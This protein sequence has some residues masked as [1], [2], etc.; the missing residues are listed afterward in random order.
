MRKTWRIV[1]GAALMTG[2]LCAAGT[3]GTQTTRQVPPPPRPPAPLPPLP[4]TQLDDRLPAFKQTFSLSFSD[5][6]PIRDVLLLMLKDTGLSVVIDPDVTG[7]FTG[8]LAGVTLKQALDITLQPLALEYAIEN[9]VL[10]VFRRPTETRF[11][12]VNHVAT[13]RSGERTTGA[14]TGLATASR[15]ADGVPAPGA[16]V[17]SSDATDFYDEVGRTVGTLLSRDGSFTVDRKAGL[18]RVTDYPER[19]ERVS[20]YLELAEL[21]STRQVQIR[22]TFVDVTLRDASS[23][24]IDWRAVLA[25]AGDA[26][27]PVRSAAG[28]AGSSPTPRL[29]VRNFDALLRA[30]AT[31][32]MVN[33]LAS[34]AV[35]TL[36]NEPAIVRMGTPRASADAVVLAIT[37]QVSEDGMIQMDVAPALVQQSGRPGSRAGHGAS[38]PATGG[39]DTLVRIHEGETIVLGGLEIGRAHV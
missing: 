33:V 15:S 11:F 31:Q 4:A 39:A 12:S 18:L 3:A 2:V 24:G 27:S 37:P 21:R 13:R 6:Q 9:N 14:A 28:E 35:S 23:A 19:L 26:V 36:N 17:T 16:T 22:A 38:V 32:G 34:P 8:E 1:L 25:S 29:I 10:H 20:R 30:L 5:A 7:T